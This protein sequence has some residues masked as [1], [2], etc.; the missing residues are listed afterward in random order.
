MHSTMHIYPV[1][2][3][4]GRVANDATAWAYRD[5][6]YAQVI[7]GVDP[8]PANAQE[9]HPLD[10]RLLRRAP[11][12]LHGR[13][14]RELHDGRR[15]G[16][17][18]GDVPREL[19]PPGEDQGEVRPGRTSSTSTR[20]SSP[21]VD[22]MF[23]AS[24]AGG[25][26]ASAFSRRRSSTASTLKRPAPNTAGTSARNAEGQVQLVA[27]VPTRRV[28]PVRPGHRDDRHHH[29]AEDR[30]LRRA[31]RTGRARGRCRRR[32]R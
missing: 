12:V 21:R 8:D 3:A 22:A 2:G 20:T 23:G 30:E 17:S 32:T 31:A 4:A 9:H 15:P 13:R 26:G 28:D 6:R 1:D 11:P 10:H 7:V 18:P 29:V 27:G 25:G 14:L 16:T 24:S 19:R 5:A